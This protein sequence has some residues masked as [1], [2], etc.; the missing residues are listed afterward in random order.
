MK[1]IIFL[2]TLLLAANQLT[3]SSSSSSSSHATSAKSL[4]R[5][6]WGGGP[7]YV[8]CLTETQ[9]RERYE[10]MK[11]AG[12][13]TGYFYA[14][15]AYPDKGCVLKGNN[16]YYG[17]GG[18]EEEMNLPVAG[19]RQRIW[20][21]EVDSVEAVE[22][23]S[24]MPT[25]GA[26]SVLSMM[27]SMGNADGS[28]P[29]LAKSQM[30][31]SMVFT[32]M[33][34]PSKTDMSMSIEQSEMIIDSSTN[35]VP[36]AIMSMDDIDMSMSIAQSEMSM[37]LAL[38][39][40]SVP[41]LTTSEIDL[42]G[43]ASASDSPNGA[44]A[45]QEGNEDDARESTPSTVPPSDGADENAEEGVGTD[46]VVDEEGTG[47]LDTIGNVTDTVTDFFGNISVPF[48]NFSSDDGAAATSSGDF[49]TFG[50]GRFACLVL[51]T[52]SLSFVGGQL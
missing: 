8:P 16:F 14:G 44:P 7:Q 15:D 10:L 24:T 50:L 41:P 13:L 35:D 12:V 51:V 4:R 31:M 36:S 5:R 9:C 11:T 25:I 52:L 17:S 2:T 42:G 27:M 48:A 28:M 19:E 20:C 43:I 29:M 22:T 38:T 26:D 37:S 47:F 3:A 40:M 23:T 33:S 30:S 6:L 21:E 46:Q 45:T 1:G 34:M 49:A 39:D 18:T 32:D